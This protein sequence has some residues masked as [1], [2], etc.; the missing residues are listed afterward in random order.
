MSLYITPLGRKKGYTRKSHVKLKEKI[1]N[2]KYKKSL[3]A[4]LN[5]EHRKKGS[6]VTTTH[7]TSRR[8]ISNAA[9]HQFDF[10]ESMFR[11]Q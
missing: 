1:A 10:N 6:N 5:K 11:W 2:E 3:F 4:K 8:K 7:K 9:R